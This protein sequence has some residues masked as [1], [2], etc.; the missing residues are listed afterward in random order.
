MSKDSQVITSED[1][2]KVYKFYSSFYDFVFGQIFK[3][4]RVKVAEIV[5]QITKS[6]DNILE[7]GVGTGLSL[8]Y[9]NQDLNITGID[10]SSHMLKIARERVR[11]KELKNIKSLLEM[12]AQNTTFKDNSF[13]VVVAMYVVTVVPD[14]IAFFNELKRICKKGGEIIIINH[15]SSTVKLLLGLEKIL[16][17][18]SAKI[19]FHPNLSLKQFLQ[20]ANMKPINIES[21]NLFNGWNIIRFVNG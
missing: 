2:K 16:S 4:G 17:S 12:D 9:Y 1:I 3:A 21:V 10:L 6:G 11:K 15:F 13:D 5:N 7:V 8:E 14:R 20:E 18:F 19:G